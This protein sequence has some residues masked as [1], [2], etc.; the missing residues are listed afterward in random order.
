MAGHSHWA[1]IKHKKGAIDRK[2]GKIWGKI[3]KKIMVAAKGGPDPRDNLS[4]R[5]IIDEAKAANMPKD[6]IQKAI[7][8]GSGGTGGEGFEE[9][10]YEGYGPAGVAVLV[11]TLTDNRNR[12][13][14][15]MRHSFER[16]GG[17]L[18]TSGSVAFQFS[19][20]GVFAISAGKVDEEKLMEVA[21]EAGADDVQTQEGTFIVFCPMTSFAALK[22]ALEAAGIKTESAELTNVPQNTVELNEEDARKVLKLI[23]TLEDNDDVQNVSHNADI[24]DAALQEA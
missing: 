5:Y 19:K 18:G 13:A 10:V 22:D 8:K 23:D 4:L 20:Q 7:E 14:P 3:A 21:L 12:T 15:E 24:P 16:S 11:E 1:N 9:V 2:R 17:S 6:T